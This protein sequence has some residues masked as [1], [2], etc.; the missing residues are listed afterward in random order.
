MPLLTTREPVSGVPHF[1]R[2]QP[3]PGSAVRRTDIV[4]YGSLDTVAPTASIVSVSRTKTSRVAGYDATDVVWTSDE[5]FVAYQ[6]RVVSSASDPVTSGALIE[7]D[8]NP[9]GGGTAGVQYTST[10]T[11]AELETASAADG[12]KLIKLFVQDAAGNWST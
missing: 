6:L 12:S 3:P 10:I 9:A 2:S 8:Q 1:Y 5:D 4:V 7:Q 11:E